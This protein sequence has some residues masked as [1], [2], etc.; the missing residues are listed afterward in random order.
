MSVLGVILV[1]IFPHSDWVRTRISPNMDT[2]HAEW[3]WPWPSQK[4]FSWSNF[5]K[6]RSLIRRIIFCLF[7]TSKQFFHFFYGVKL[8][9]RIEILKP[10]FSSSWKWVYFHRK[11]L[12]KKQDFFSSFHFVIKFWFMLNLNFLLQITFLTCS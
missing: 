11:V 7:Q 4:P 5:L 10:I 8:K 6:L 12:K 2:F 3:P 9:K 1:C